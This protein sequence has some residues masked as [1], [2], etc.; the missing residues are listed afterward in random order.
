MSYSK[1]SSLSVVC[2]FGA[3]ACA[4]EPERPMTP[5]ASWTPTEIAPPPAPTTLSEPQTQS[6][7]AA[8]QADRSAIADPARSSTLI[9]T[10][11]CEREVRCKNVGGEEGKYVTQE[12]C[13]VSLEPATRSELDARDCPKG[14]SEV[15]LTECTEEIKQ[16]G[17]DSPV[18]NIDLITE[19][20]N[21]EICVD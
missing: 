7:P 10:A 6:A 14:V 3:I 19:C 1:I 16:T 11:R 2:L 12:D 21:D 20:S 15:E 17:C 13:V 5:A 8:Q 4:S 9:A 18:Q